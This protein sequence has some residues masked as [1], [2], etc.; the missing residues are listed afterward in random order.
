V[1]RV[2]CY[3]AA[4]YWSPDPL[5]R[6]WNVARACA[7]ARLAAVSNRAAITVHPGIAPTFGT[8]ET[9]ETRALGLAVDETLVELVARTVLGEL[10]ILETDA[11]DLTPGVARELRAW[12]RARGRF[13]GRRGTWADYRQAFRGA[14][15]EDLWK[16]L[17]RPPTA[18]D[19][20][21]W[22]AQLGGVAP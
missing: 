7:L 20:A 5:I 9:P 1:I 6:S 2:P 22:A 17:E 4:P 18:E 21:A 11:G 3:I 10:W 14:G 13:A 16:A 15:L 12:N 8:T 19:L